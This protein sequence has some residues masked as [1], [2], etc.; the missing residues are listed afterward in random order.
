MIFED[1]SECFSVYKFVNS[2]TCST[3]QGTCCTPPSPPLFPPPFSFP[4]FSFPSLPSYPLHPSPSLPFP[5]LPFRSL[6]FHQVKFERKLEG[7][8]TTKEVQRTIF[9]LNNPYPQKKM[10]TFNK[11]THDF[12]LHRT[13]PA[14]GGGEEVGCKWS[15]VPGWVVCVCGAVG[16]GVWVY[17]GGGVHVSLCV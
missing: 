6:L 9:G 5:S 7:G 2:H 1:Y 16:V 12:T 3:M 4:P 10:M 13:G 11:M 14:G 15:G 17:V 8:S